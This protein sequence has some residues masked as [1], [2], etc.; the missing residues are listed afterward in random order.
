MKK[1]LGLFLFSLA[2]S[3]S[4]AFAG[5]GSCDNTCM[6]KYRDCMS[7]G[8]LPAGYCSS[9][10]AHCLAVCGGADGTPIP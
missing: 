1:K 9:N 5:N 7:R 3:A 6:L 4:Y 2:M 10:L 8:W